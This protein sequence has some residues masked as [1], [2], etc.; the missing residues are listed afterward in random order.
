MN[1]SDFD[2]PIADEHTGYLENGIEVLG[3][4]TRDKYKVKKYLLLC[5][6]CAEDPELYG[7]GVFSAYWGNIN[8]GRLSCGCGKNAR[9]TPEQYLIRLNRVLNPKG[10]KAISYA[11][12]YKGN[13]T[14]VVC[15][16]EKHGEWRTGCVGLL[17]QGVGCP[18]CKAD[19]TSQ[20]CAYKIDKVKEL[21]LKT[22]CFHPD[23]E[24]FDTDK[25]TS[26]GKRYVE[27][28][29][30]E[31]DTR[32]KGMQETIISGS[33][34]C[35]CGG[36]RQKEAYIIIAEDLHSSSVFIK[37]GIANNSVRRLWDHKVRNRN[38]N[39]TLYGVWEFAK[40]E[41][42]YKAESMCKS[43][44]DCS[45]LS[46]EY[47]PSGWTETTWFYNL[48]KVIKIYEDSGGERKL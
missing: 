28:Y 10:M 18:S 23:T 45:I 38:F 8:K 7:D 21:A 11:E 29:C 30:P 43:F 47:M 9:V 22:G 6:V 26:A 39:F 19:L 31:C 37:F 24:F 14:K 33:R 34:P 2:D 1:Y 35:D 44:L 12:D 40:K 32:A 42:C 36:N 17:I 25:R 3:W 27:I 4:H 41:H 48:E 5:K 13:E 20:R 16:C 15:H 46:P